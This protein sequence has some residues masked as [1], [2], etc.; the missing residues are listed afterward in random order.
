MFRQELAKSLVYSRRIMKDICDVRFKQDNIR[1]LLIPLIIF[2]TD[3][4]PDIVFGPHLVASWF[5]TRLLHM[6]D[7]LRSLRVEHR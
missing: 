4:T 6:H 5:I 2:A 7:V 1:T 3:T